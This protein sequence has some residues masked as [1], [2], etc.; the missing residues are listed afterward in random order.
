[1]QSH[2]V[3]TDN[4]LVSPCKNILSLTETSKHISDLS[5][6]YNAL[7]E[8]KNFHLKIVQAEENVAYFSLPTS[9]ILFLDNSEDKMPD[10]VL[11]HKTHCICFP[12]HRNH[13][14]CLLAKGY[15][16]CTIWDVGEG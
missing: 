7:V 16:Y 8:C 11:R 14:L 3:Y 12:L 4:L 5:Q 13:I 2:A 10:V 6:D 1:M 9:I 15:K